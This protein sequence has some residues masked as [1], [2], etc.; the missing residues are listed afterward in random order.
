MADTLGRVMRNWSFYVDE[1]KAIDA[2][3]DTE[4]PDRVTIW[5]PKRRLAMCIEQMAR[6]ISVYCKEEIVPI[7]FLG[8]LERSQD[9]KER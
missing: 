2:N 7:D 6:A 5:V 1:G 4:W 8:K 9:E 3:G